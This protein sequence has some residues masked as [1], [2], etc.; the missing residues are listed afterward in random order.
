MELGFHGRLL[1]IKFGAEMCRTTKGH[2][3]MGYGQSK[4]LT[5]IDGPANSDLFR[6]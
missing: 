1:Q 6:Q 4:I 2:E 3:D 5:D